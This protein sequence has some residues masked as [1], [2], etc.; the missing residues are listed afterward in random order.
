MR[1]TR[2]MNRRIGMA[3]AAVWLLGGSVAAQAAEI[4]VSAAAAAHP[5]PAAQTLG[6]EP[7]GVEG[8]GDGFVR[9]QGQ[10]QPPAGFSH[11]P[12]PTAS[13]P[14]PRCPRRGR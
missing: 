1:M 8:P 2:L 3:V 5:A 12:G 6:R 4:T 9:P 10:E 11:P 7:G 14:G 13:P